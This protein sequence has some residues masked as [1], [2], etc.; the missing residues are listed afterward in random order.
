MPSPGTYA[1]YPA[2]TRLDQVMT[3][4][5]KK[6]RAWSLVVGPLAEPSGDEPTLNLGWI[7]R[8]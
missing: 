1:T 8:P 2:G 7:R 6:G 5:D 3:V 4:T